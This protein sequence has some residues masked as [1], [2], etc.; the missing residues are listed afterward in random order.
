MAS[1]ELKGTGSDPDV[2]RSERPGKPARSSLSSNDAG[3][4]RRAYDPKWMQPMLPRELRMI[5]AA[6]AVPE[7]RRKS[8]A[9]APIPIVAHRPKL[10][11]GS[12]G[13]TE[14]FARLLH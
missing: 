8:D 11:V 10:V 9:L 1:A 6:G 4:C 12:R 13:G 5:H 14:R 3:S 2:A 7:I